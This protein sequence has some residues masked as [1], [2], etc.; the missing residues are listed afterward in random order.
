MSDQIEPVVGNIILDSSAIVVAENSSE[1]LVLFSTLRAD[2]VPIKPHDL[3][4]S[5]VEHY[6][7]YSPRCAICNSPHRNLLEQVYINEGKVVTRTIDFF[8]NHYGAKLNFA[9]M[10]SHLSKHCDFNKI[11]VPGL[12]AYTKRNDILDIWKYR[13]YELALTAMLEEIDDIKG[14]PARTLDEKIKRAGMIEKLTGRIM[15]VKEKRDD[16]TN[17][18]PNVFEVLYEL[19]EIV[20]DD[21]AKRIIREKAKELKGKL[22]E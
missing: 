22:S 14:T 7:S 4:V 2:A 13:E 9:Q 3:E 1:N 8:R 15:T 21:D 10:K 20:K 6:Q 16:S 11:E 5:Y 18:L 17:S 12:L 19:H